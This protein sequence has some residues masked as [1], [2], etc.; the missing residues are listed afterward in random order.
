M[1]HEYRRN[2]TRREA[3]AKELSVSMLPDLRKRTLKNIAKK[4]PHG[5]YI[6]TD[7]NILRK[8]AKMN[9]FRRFVSDRVAARQLDERLLAFLRYRLYIVIRECE[10]P[11]KWLRDLE[12]EK[13]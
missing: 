5:H 10:K 6:A 7:L 9:F 2:S 4:L 3:V 1:E 12:A 13:Q 11:P 8:E